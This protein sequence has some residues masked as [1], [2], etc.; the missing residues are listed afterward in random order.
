MVLTFLR[1]FQLKKHVSKAVAS[2]STISMV[3]F[4]H[5]AS[6]EYGYDFPEQ[7][8]QIGRELTDLHH[9][10]FFVCLAIMLVVTVWMF[11]SIFAHRK[12]RGFEPAKFSHSTFLE[13]LWT[14][15]PVLIL[16][17][18]AIP[19]TKML[20]RMEDTTKSDITIKVTG[21]QWKWQY[22]Y[23]QD[24]V[25]F[26]STISTPREQID[27]YSSKGGEAV[28]QGE[29]YL[30]EVDNHVVIPA[31]KKVRILLTANDVIHA[32]WV[33]KLGGKKDAIPGYI[34]E[35]W[36]RADDDA[37]GTYRG[38]CAELCGKDHAFMPI[39]VD[40]VSQADYEK[41]LTDNAGVAS[42]QIKSVA[43]TS[44]NKLQQ[45]VAATTVQ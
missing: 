15:I 3:L 21:Y 23:L 45:K 35:M 4:S 2:I 43:Q 10:V 14:A 24:G 44:S 25:D 8:T 33:P 41:W 6:A 38:R 12:S 26:Y 34:N 29:N 16:I 42:D 7:K 27:Q 28:P 9:F 11:Y 37:I 32:W 13:V 19:A 31:G 18:M 17:V 1:A 22:E 20:I 40:V 39:V 36:I 30:Q 5:I